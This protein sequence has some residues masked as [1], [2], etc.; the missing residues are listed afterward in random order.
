MA[1]DVRGQ[2]GRPCRS[3]NSRTGHGASMSRMRT[4]ASACATTVAR[5]RRPRR[6]RARRRDSAARVA[7]GPPSASPPAAEHQKLERPTVGLTASQEA[8]GDHLALVGD[9]AIARPEQRRQPAEAPVLPAA[10]GPVHDEKPGG[11][12]GSAGS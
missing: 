11:V 6:A 10:P 5:A 3:S 1:R 8:S 12:T 2:R 4:P 9:E 7:P